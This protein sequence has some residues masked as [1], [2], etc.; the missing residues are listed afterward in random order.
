VRSEYAPQFFGPLY[1]G[2]QRIKAAFDPR[3]QLNS[4]KICTPLNS[5]AGLLKI[6]RVPTRGQHDRQIPGP[7]RKDYAVAMH[8]NG[9]GAC[10]NFDPH[11]PMCPSWKG[12][13]ERIHSPKGR[14][15]L[16]REWLRLLAER[17]IDPV[18]EARQVRKA[19]LIGGFLPR[20]R[21]TLARRRGQYDFSHEVHLAM[22]G[23]LACKSCASQC[24][25]RVDVPDFRSQFLELYYGRYLRPAR[26]YLVGGL[27]YV[28]P[29]LARFPT[30]YNWAMGNRPLQALLQHHVGLVDSPRLSGIDLNTAV[31][32]RGI[33]WAT[34]KTLETL[35][36]EQRERAVIVVQDAFTR[37][38]ET[39]L[40]LDLL[41][42]LRRLGFVPLLAPFKA[43][44]KP[45]HV[46]GF[47]KA[48]QRTAERNAAMLRSLEACQ[49]PLIGID[50]SMTLTYR[51]EYPKALGRDKT[52]Q[53]L[54]IQEWLAGQKDYLQDLRM[55][56]KEGEIKLLD[57]C[58]EKA[59][60]APS[61]RDWQTVFAALGQS[62]TPINVGCCGMA[63]TY[64][65]ETIN[66]G[67]S[68]RI[69]GLSWSEVVNDPAQ[70]DRLVATGYS[71]R[72]QVRRIDG[73]VLKHPLQAL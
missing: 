20:L 3:N 48:F 49:V 50:P 31:K 51:F 69:Y 21:N 17:G 14:A 22:S 67:T 8:C 62:L 66:A 54:L 27:E 18:A 73:P 44:G 45:L 11:D 34:P 59:E 63:G 40:V 5:D 58:N 47:L 7:V 16:T 1:P 72:S 10:F 4:G 12:T 30:P 53:V 71:C 41:D 26:D 52:P 55:S 25:I 39:R 65:H 61:L 38:F 24:P 37:Y 19:S 68:R 57:D 6:D 60:T 13:R 42:L 28:I 23:C 33:G 32:K 56:L 64:G 29:Y 70:R 36:G 15:M 9:N 2:L 35:S 43:N 46:H